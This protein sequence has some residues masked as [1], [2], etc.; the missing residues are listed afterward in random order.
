[1][2]LKDLFH[3]LNEAK[4]EYDVFYSGSDSV[5]T[6]LDG[7]NK[8]EVGVDIN[9]RN[10]CGVVAASLVTFLGKKDIKAKRVEGSFIADVADTGKLSFTSQEKKDIAAKGLDFNSD[11]DRKKYAEEN[12]LI[13]E[14]R[15]IPHYW[16]V[17]STGDIIDPTV[18][19]FAKFITKPISK[20]NYQSK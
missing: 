16:T 10:N 8:A 12:N 17:T 6:L 14:L 18:R 20:S 7:F 3:Q 5:S 13:D 2:K 9:K 11:D 19:Q 1:M 15:K 4:A